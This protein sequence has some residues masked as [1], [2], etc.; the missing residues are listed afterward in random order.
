VALGLQEC[1]IQSDTVLCSSGIKT[2]DTHQIAARRSVGPFQ[3]WAVTGVSCDVEL[4]VVHGGTV[5]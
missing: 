2:P 5:H 3:S 1:S 4:R